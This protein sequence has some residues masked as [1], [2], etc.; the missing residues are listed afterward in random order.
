MGFERLLRDAK[1]GWVMGPSNEV[2][3]QLVGNVSLMGFDVVDY[4]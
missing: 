3:R 1:A 2:L 4:W